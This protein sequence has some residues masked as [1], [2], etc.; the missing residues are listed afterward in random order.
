VIPLGIADRANECFVP[1]AA[2]D[3]RQTSD[4][5]QAYQLIVTGRATFILNNA[6]AIITSRHFSTFLIA[7]S[8][9]TTK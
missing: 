8:G 5:I 1:G 6:L 4:D 2:R 9:D 3:R 7:F